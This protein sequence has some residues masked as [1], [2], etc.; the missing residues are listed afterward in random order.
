MGTVRTLAVFIALVAIPLASS[1]G[2]PCESD[3][4]LLFLQSVTRILNRDFNRADLSYL[5]LD[6]HSGQL[7]DSRWDDPER[8]IALGSLVKPFTALAYGEQNG[9]R[10]PRHVCH[11]TVSG[12]WLSRGHGQLNLTAAVENSCNAYFRVLAAAVDSQSLS[13]VTSRFGIEPPSA[14]ATTVT[15]VGIG[16]A[17]PI[18]PLH[19]ARA[20]LE[21]IRRRD[22]PG[23]R[24]IVDGMALSAEKGTGAAVDRA[25]V[26]QKALVKTGTAPCTHAEHAP[27]DGFVIVGFP[28]DSPRILLLLRVHGAPGAQAAAVAGNILKQIGE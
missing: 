27:G 26:P 19:M 9:Y 16:S 12:C 13:S 17:W 20:Y 5:L 1:G 7:I 22:Q 8:P 14:S 3:S 18:S 11:G 28:A 4:D 10:Y 25:L 21:L 2:S 23:I 24:E 6:A 15:F